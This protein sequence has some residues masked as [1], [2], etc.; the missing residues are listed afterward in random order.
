MVTPWDEDEEFPVAD[1]KYAVANDDTRQG[2][3]D[4]VQSQREMQESG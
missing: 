3:L 2:Y 4:W 1:W